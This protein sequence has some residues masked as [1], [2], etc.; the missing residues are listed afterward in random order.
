MSVLS[1]QHSIAAQVG[2]DL[3]AHVD[4]ALAGRERSIGGL[5]LVPCDAPGL[6]PPGPDVLATAEKLAGLTAQNRSDPDAV[7]AQLLALN[8]DVSAYHAAQRKSDKKAVLQQLRAR[9]ARASITALY[10]RMLYDPYVAVEAEYQNRPRVVQTV[11][12]HVWGDPRYSMPLPGGGPT[13]GRR[14]LFFLGKFPAEEEFKQGRCMCG[15]S[16]V[17]FARVLSELQVPDWEQA[18]VSNLSRFFDASPSRPANLPE[19]WVKDCLPLV[20]AEIKLLRPKVV[21]VLG[22]E[23]VKAMIDKK[24][25]VGDASLR[26]FEKTVDLRRYADEPEQLHTFHVVACPHPASILHDPDRSTEPVRQSVSYLRGVLER[27]AD[28][29]TA[30]ARE[31]EADIEHI[32]LESRE[33]LGYLAE[34]LVGRGTREYAIDAEWDGRFP[35]ERGAFIRCVQFSWAAKKAA[36][37]PVMTSERGDYWEGGWEPTRKILQW[38][39]DRRGVRPIGHNFNSDLVFLSAWGLRFLE[40]LF[41]AP[42]DDPDPEDPNWRPGFLKIKDEGGWDTMIG[43]HAVDEVSDLSLKTLLR[44]HTSVPG[45]ED[46]LKRWIDGY[47]KEHKI[48]KSRLTGYGPV[49]DRLLFPY[50]MYD[51]DGTYRLFDVQRGTPGQPGLLE[52]DRYGL[53]SWKPFWLTMRALPALLEIHRTGMSLDVPLAEDLMGRFGEARVR[54]LAELRRLIAWGEVRDTEGKL[55]QKA[56]NPNSQPM[57]KALFFGDAYGRDRKGGLVR[58]GNVVPL[59]LT[60]YKSTGKKPK[61]FANLPP[62]Q[63]GDYNP[64]VDKEVMAVLEK[65]DDPKN[66]GRG[67]VRQMQLFRFADQV[68]KIFRPPAK[69]AEPEA[70]PAAEADDFVPDFAEDQEHRID[71][72]PAPPQPKYESLTF[73]AEMSGYSGGIMS[74]ICSDYR[75]RTLIFPTTETGRCRSAKPNMQNVTFKRRSKDF[76]KLIGDWYKD[77]PISSVFH[78]G[79]GCVFVKRDYKGAELVGMAVNAQDRNMIDHCMRNRLPESDPR[80]ICIHSKVAIRA[81]D[82][83]KPDGSPLRPAAGEL[84]KYGHS[85]KRDAAKPVDFGYAYGMTAETAERRMKEQGVEIEE[86]AGA[87]LISGLESEYPCLPVFY[88][89]CRT[90]SQS[91]GWIESCH[92]R[93]R[94]FRPT[95]D[96][97]VVGDQERQAMNFPIQAFVADHVNIAMANWSDWKEAN[98]NSGARL[99]LQVHDALVWEVPAAEATQFALET[100]RD[101]MDDVLFWPTTLDGR[102]INDPNAPYKLVSDLEVS[103]RYDLPFAKPEHF[104]AAGLDPQYFLKA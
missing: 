80:H 31:R 88:A 86:G 78:A 44:R 3:I 47:C 101:L 59:G 6:P 63:W 8:V 65:L 24:L 51:T 26:V 33:D 30:E 87:L 45:Y 15:K 10:L 4:S 82:L 40:D 49:P 75:V 28:R 102:T 89:G 43:Q 64:S 70:V 29:V 96:R 17:E 91:P 53:P 100:S 11:P 42:K 92:G 39:W 27:G 32:V 90:A 2:G 54:T 9:V 97:K 95:N 5:E 36:L 48:T 83:K 73:N 81:F 41:K 56:F 84:K 58:P 55:V 50:G 20:W 37:V 34:H 67:V 23:P 103:S 46:E 16:G 76:V 60:P 69:A 66:G 71:A 21:V 1:F 7:V 52:R 68:L 93:R 98:P 38:M 72:V 57:C 22:A 61:L 25:N 94:R 35:T 12:G 99:A 79:P 77:H 18:Y 13:G 62:E 19:R 14:D 104:A 74:F 85:D